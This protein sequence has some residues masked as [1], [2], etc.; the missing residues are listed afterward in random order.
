MLY[1]C[2]CG[3]TA[4]TATEFYRHLASSKDAASGHQLVQARFTSTPRKEAG[5]GATSAQGAVDGPPQKNPQATWVDEYLLVDQREEGAQQRHDAGEARLP[6]SVPAASVAPQQPPETGSPLR[7]TQPEQQ[8]QQQQG[9]PRG[10][11]LRRPRSS[12]VLA[13]AARGGPAGALEVDSDDVE[14]IERTNSYARGGAAG[15]SRSAQSALRV[16]G[17]LMTA[18]AVGLSPWRWFGGSNGGGG[19]GE[20]G[21]GL[22]GPQQGAAGEE[23]GGAGGGLPSVQEGGLDGGGEAWEQ[24]SDAAG[25]GVVAAR[26]EAQL[27]PPPASLAA[28]HDITAVLMW[29]N[30]W[31]TSRIFGAGLYLAIC[32]RQLV[33]GHD[34]VQ[35]STALLA[36]CF[37]AL[38]RNAV[39]QTLATYRRAQ[40]QQQQQMREEGGDEDEQGRAAAS[41]GD[42]EAERLEVLLTAGA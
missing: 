42:E 41:A 15:T 26:A 9:T 11:G 3:F 29:R 23:G 39:R 32:A 40:Q 8:Q 25:A 6:T 2:S 19:E 36:A 14:L 13:A 31:H 4:G 5:I 33:R 30:P 18:I 7:G 22:A 16:S 35:P 24:G 28:L 20:G 12:T 1:E 10:W 27:P 38:M 37:L 17:T 34:L 21:E